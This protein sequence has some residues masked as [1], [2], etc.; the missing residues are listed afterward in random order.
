MSVDLYEILQV[1]PDADAAALKKAYRRLA[2]KYH[3]DQNLGDQASEERFKEVKHAY[4]VLSDPQRRKAYDRLRRRNR[5]DDA[6]TPWDNLGELFGAINSAIAAG[7]DGLAKSSREGKA[8][9]IHVDLT[10]DLEDTLRGVRRDVTVPRRHRCKACEGSGAADAGAWARCDRCRGSG[11]VQ[12]AQGFFSLMRDCPKCAG[13][14]R[15]PDPPCHH[16]EGNG[17]IQGTELLP[18][19]IPAGVRDGQTLRWK[20]KGVR[21]RGTRPTGD[22]LVT[23]H[24][25][26]HDEFRRE[27]AD[28]YGTASAS[29]KVAS[30][31]G[32]VDVRTLD[33]HVRMKVPPGTRS[34]KVFRLRGKG[35]PEVGEDT[36]GDLYIRL[37]IDGDRRHREGAQSWNQTKKKERGFFDRVK[38]LFDD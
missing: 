21:G 1:D 35:L 23:V 31:G 4:E 10:L 22:L 33:G 20:G 27:G 24:I 29:F 16:C 7:L 34:G 15:V 28:L 25:S 19:D 11:Q 36:R 30:L 6:A 9:N 12:E 2:L 38:D 5:V 26:D 17:F 13:T 37:V 18:V 32:E 8:E 14:G 3:P